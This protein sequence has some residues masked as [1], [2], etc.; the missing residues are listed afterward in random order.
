MARSF[1][2][3]DIPTNIPRANQTIYDNITRIL[4]FY[5]CWSILYLVL[6]WLSKVLIP[7]VR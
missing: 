2:N 4:A 1:S 7:P 6:V 5:V 3:V